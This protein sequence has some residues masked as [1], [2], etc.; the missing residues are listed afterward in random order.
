MTEVSDHNVNKTP[1]RPKAVSTKAL[2]DYPYATPSQGG[3]STVVRKTKQ[4]ESFK[5]TFRVA[6]P[7]KEKT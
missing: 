5:L 2:G 1:D 7:E 6:K 4:Q 3:D